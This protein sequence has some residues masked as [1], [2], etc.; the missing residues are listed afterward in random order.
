MDKY[1]DREY[2]NPNQKKK[3]DYREDVICMYLDY[4]IH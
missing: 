2:P 3:S 1:Q 4:P